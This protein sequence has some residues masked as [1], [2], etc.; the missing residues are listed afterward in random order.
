M[1]KRPLEKIVTMGEWTW[2]VRPDLEDKV[3]AMARSLKGLD[4]NP[5]AK[6]IKTTDGRRSIWTAP[7]GDLGMVFI[8]RYSRPAIGRRLKQAVRNSRTRQEWEMGLRLEAMG[9]PAARHLAMAEKTRGGLL[10]EDLLVQEY[11]EDHVSLEEW[12]EN[13]PGHARGIDLRVK[14]EFM[15]R[16]ARLIRRL[17]DSGVIQRDFKPDSIMVSPSGELKLVDLERALIKDAP[18]GLS[19]Q[20]RLDNLAKIDQSSIFIGST[21]DRLR[22]LD[23][24]FKTYPIGKQTSITIE[25]RWDLAKT[26]GIKAEYEC[27]KQA[28]A[29]MAWARTKNS[30]YDRYETRGFTVSAHYSVPRET[31]EGVIKRIRRPEEIKIFIPRGKR[32]REDQTLEARW[33]GAA[34]A[35][36]LTPA[37][38]YRRVPFIPARAAITP[39]GSDWGL[40]LQMAPGPDMLPWR[41][42]ALE[43]RKN[44]TA[45][46]F[47]KALGS[48]LRI[49]SRM[50]IWTT[51]LSSDSFMYDPSASRPR[52]AFLL[53][54]LDLAAMNVRKSGR[55]WEKALEKVALFMNLE[56]DEKECLAR[57]F[58]RCLLRSFNAPKYR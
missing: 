6:K 4:K 57:A 13:W 32:F 36:E 17:H 12:A 9:L 20:D 28:V 26:I 30:M 25:Q 40:L 2:R 58:G 23:Q 56:P 18:G 49:M 33:T 53:Y 34:R 43:A 11:L 55:E 51:E 10:E 39:A 41:E 24:Y 1:K 48:S 44:G 14:R 27:A 8:K 47:L 22:F 31:I 29:R 7:A 5:R 35:L 46:E 3:E 19:R 42:A 16:L 21:S 50:G 45:G 15:T 54:R 37:L 38:V 52:H